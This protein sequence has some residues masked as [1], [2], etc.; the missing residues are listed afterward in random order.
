MS[1]QK[2]LAN[3]ITDPKELLTLLKIDESWLERAVYASRAFPLRVTRSFV[4]RMVSGDIH[5]PLLKQVLPLAAELDELADYTTDP[6]QEQLVN[7]I[8]GLLHKYAGRVLVMPTGACAIHCRYCFRRHFPYHDNNLGA[9]GLHAHIDYLQQN[10]EITEVILS[11]G[12][13]LVIN[14]SVLGRLCERLRA[15]PQLKRL[16][17]HSRLPIVLPERITLDLIETLLQSGLQLI[18]VIHCNHPQEIN[19]EVIAALAKL[20][21]HGITLLNQMVLLKGVN[22]SAQALIDLNERLFAAGVLPYYLHQL[23]KV[24]GT[25]HFAVPLP[26]A[27]AIY[28]ELTRHLPGYLVPKWVMEEPGAVAKTLL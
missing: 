4:S 28:T 2:S 15:L 24:Q 19:H 7:P 16:R 8:P 27:Q 21:V 10:P 6:L 26:E 12:D 3:L 14:D 1:W 5:D 25:Q 13:P 9:E 23:D 22:D 20:R 11:G 18:L 17:I